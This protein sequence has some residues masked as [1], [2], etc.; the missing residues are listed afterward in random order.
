MKMLAVKKADGNA[1]LGHS[2]FGNCSQGTW[3]SSPGGVGLPAPDY[4][5][6]QMVSCLLLKTFLSCQKPR[7]RGKR[8]TA[9][10]VFIRRD[11][12]ASLHAAMIHRNHFSA[13]FEHVVDTTR[14]RGYHN[15]NDHRQYH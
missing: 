9:R 13:P 11:G 1:E 14:H 3:A 2:D 8:R 15:D 7:L 6:H 5:L 4:T 12:K 10:V